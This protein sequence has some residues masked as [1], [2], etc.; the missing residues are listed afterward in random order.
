MSNNKFYKTVMTV[1]VLSQ[2]P[3]GNVSL[4]SLEEMM[5]DDCSGV[6][7]VGDSEELSGPQMA[8]ELLGQ[9]SDPEFFG[10]DS[11]G[12]DLGANDD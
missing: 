4:S 12:M 8:Q 6:I 1:T 5:N 7:Q 10:L 3:I 11:N 2:Y 9:D